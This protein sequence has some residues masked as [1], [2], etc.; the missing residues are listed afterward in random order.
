M[1]F[2]SI[3]RNLETARFQRHAVSMLLAFIMAL[4]VAGP[5]WPQDPRHDEIELLI[6]DLLNY[7]RPGEAVAA[8]QRLYRMGPD[9]AT[10]IPALIEALHDGNRDVRAYSA[11]ALSQIGAAAVMPLIDVVET[12]G[13]DL[14][15]MH[16]IVALARMGTIASEAV[17]ILIRKIVHT[18][19]NIASAAEQALV[20]FRSDAVP[21][22]NDALSDE[23]PTIR[24][25]VAFILGKIGALAKPAIPALTD[26][27]TDS[28]VNVRRNSA[29]AL[30][31][32]G[33]DDPIAVARLTAAMSDVGNTID[34]RAMA[35]TS[36][37]RIVP[38]S[39]DVVTPLIASLDTDNADLCNA[40]AQAL[41]EFPGEAERIVPS[42]IAA[43]GD[44]RHTP[45]R[46]F[47]GCGHAIDALGNMGAGAIEAIPILVAEMSG[48]RRH[49]MP[50]AIEAALRSISV[51]LEHKRQ[52][53]SDSQLQEAI[54]FLQ[55]GR[56]T[57]Q[58]DTPEE[59][60]GTI[61]LLTLTLESRKADRLEIAISWLG[62]H[63]TAVGILAYLIGVPTL[64]FL[65][66]WLR[67]IWIL[68]INNV[69]KQMADIRLPGWA[70][71]ITVPVST[72]LLVGLFHYH[73]RVLDAWVAAHAAT[74]RRR[75]ELKDTVSGRNV[76]IGVPVVVDGETVPDFS[77]RTLRPIFD[78]RLSCTLIQG[79]GGSGKT[80]LA[81][82]IA[83][84]A[85]SET[86]EDRPTD[87]IMLPI[88][89][90]HE[91]DFAVD[92]GADPLTEAI[93]RQLQDLIESPSPV[94]PDLLDR[95][96]RQQRVLVI[97]DHLSEM[98]GAT[99]AK[100]QPGA[101][102]FPANAL[103]VTSR[104]NEELG[105]VVRS[106]IEPLRVAGNRLSSFMEAYLVKR[107]KRHLLDDQAFFD[108][109][110]ALSAMVGRRRI[111]VL[112][113]KL[114][115][116]Q[117]I[118]LAEEFGEAAQ[119][120]SIPDLMLKYLNRINRGITEN[121]LDDRV[122]HADAKRIAWMCL[123]RR[124]RPGDAP[125]DDVHQALGGPDAQARLSYLESRLHLVQIRQPA[126][127]RI[128][129]V[130]DPMAEYLAG[131]HLVDMLGSATEDWRD[132][133]VRL[134]QA[135]GAPEAIRGF[136]LAVLDCCRADDGESEIPDF[137]EPALVRLADG[138]DPP[139]EVSTGHREVV[140][141]AARL[142][143]ADN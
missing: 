60:S 129:I 65:I 139:G 128:R 8:A 54:S 126:Q 95:L 80:S 135:P 61:G 106:L 97:V 131:L 121:R 91:L 71:G 2:G 138:G 140:A 100:I 132:F 12:D 35:A 20:S 42:L 32:I 51:G 62:E 119:P 96:L 72:L 137:V 5:A 134:Q 103:I 112:L 26:A 92:S 117:M 46:G 67:P 11:A 57:L 69:V 34:V 142:V 15:T 127:D 17:P 68:R 53:L 13:H 50:S 24:S 47:V 33:E 105:G 45:A 90:E 19:R 99:H 120:Q 4:A 56:D 41:G 59:W 102:N 14:A 40:A 3:L 38:T 75:F 83:R 70:G 110:R 10:A 7:E 63:K 114:Y 130:L 94:R 49:L 66:L 28:E 30:G 74:A 113:A 85:M 116:E 52:E 136:V 18:N 9:A 22:L 29:E 93:G 107:K 23:D 86:P 1:S 43:L 101:P 88:L 76:H 27:L 109:C 79:E 84:W 44:E 21:E 104:L 108:G 36:L 78:R 25:R 48:I 31:E 89:I 87:H 81:C 123:E 82:Q 98:S 133:L 37:G 39:A 124:F 64:C 73:S 111:T 6:D 115:A 125:L 55:S 143:A 122:V 141:P 58:S 118:V 77:S 16:A